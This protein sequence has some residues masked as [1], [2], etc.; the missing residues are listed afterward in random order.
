MGFCCAEVPPLPNVHDHAVGVL[1]ELSVKNTDNGADPDA[2]DVKNA[3]TGGDPTVA[4]DA[5]TNPALVVV[6]DPAEFVACKDTVNV[7]ADV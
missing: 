3:A 1:V 6:A 4:V 5:T 2:G 7:P